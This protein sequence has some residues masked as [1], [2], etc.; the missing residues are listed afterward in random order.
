MQALAE[1]AV[2]KHLHMVSTATAALSS[3]HQPSHKRFPA[4]D[5][6]SKGRKSSK[7]K[8][9]LNAQLA[10]MRL[11]EAQGSNTPQLT[12]IECRIGTA[13]DPSKTQG[14]LYVL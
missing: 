7:A 14:F 4:R 1:E 6:E 8:L 13:W 10:C 12:E 5:S 3:R 11:G 9:K 2:L